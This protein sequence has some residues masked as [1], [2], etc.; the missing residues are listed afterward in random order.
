[1][2]KAQLASPAPSARRPTRSGVA[3]AHRNLP[4]LLLQARERV[5][6]RFRPLLNEAGL[7]EQQWRV[8]RA[9]LEQGPLEPREIVERCGISSPSLAGV[10]ARMDELGLVR[11]ERLDHDQRR[12]SVQATPAARRIAQDLA[13]RIDLTYRALEHQLGADFLAQVYTTIDALLDALDSGA[14]GPRA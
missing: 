5:M 14:S 1:M 12:L 11:R 13:P 2:P 7:T 4:L 9:L 6:M 10:L 8:L 3:L